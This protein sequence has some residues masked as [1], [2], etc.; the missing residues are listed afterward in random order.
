MILEDNMNECSL[1]GS[2]LKQ[3][4]GKQTLEM[5]L[6]YVAHRLW[7]HFFHEESTSA[8]IHRKWFSSCGHRSE[9]E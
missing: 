9:S 8:A 1:W 2:L 6:D 5:R 7:T 4:T 3:Q